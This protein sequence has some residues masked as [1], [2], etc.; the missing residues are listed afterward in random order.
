MPVLGN[1]LRLRGLDHNQ[2][3]WGPSFENI[4]NFCKRYEVRS[5]N[6]V[7]IQNARLPNHQKVICNRF[8]R[9]C[10]KLSI[11]DIRTACQQKVRSINCIP[12]TDKRQ[13]RDFEKPKNSEKTTTSP[14]KFVKRPVPAI[15]RPGLFIVMASECFFFRRRFSTQ[16]T[17]ISWTTIS[18]SST[19]PIQKKSMV[20]ML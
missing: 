20:A 9:L 6:S 13:E 18:N 15:C 1:H 10:H 5:K 12:S 17:N 2:L 14:D 3:H 7:G 19:R 11:M 8:F 16:L 4:P